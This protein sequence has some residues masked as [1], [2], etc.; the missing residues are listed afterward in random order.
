MKHVR[1]FHL[2]ELE[3]EIVIEIDKTSYV[4]ACAV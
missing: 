4:E 2:K 1:Q 3:L